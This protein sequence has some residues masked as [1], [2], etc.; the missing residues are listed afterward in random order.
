MARQSI[1]PAS[2]AMPVISTPERLTLPTWT[3][4]DDAGA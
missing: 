3:V 2:A 1:Q 4:P